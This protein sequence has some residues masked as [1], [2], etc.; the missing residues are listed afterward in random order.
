MPGSDRI[1][2]APS[3]TLHG[4]VADVIIY[5]KG[6]ESLC[7]EQATKRK[8]SRDRRCLAKCLTLSMILPIPCEK[9]KVS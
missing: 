8:Q 4:T 7:A 6:L 5:V 2:T 3:M 1:K 9:R